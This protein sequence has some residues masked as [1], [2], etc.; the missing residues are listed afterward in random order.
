LSHNC[1]DFDKLSLTS[2]EP[3]HAVAIV[4]AVAGG[5]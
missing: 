2:S 3:L 5:F 4:K 1:G